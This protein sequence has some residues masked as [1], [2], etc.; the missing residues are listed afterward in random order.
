MKIT[1]KINYYLFNTIKSIIYNSAVC[2][3]KRYNEGVQSNKISNSNRLIYFNYNS[4]F[5]SFRFSF[6]SNTY[7]GNRRFSNNDV[8]YK[9]NINDNNINND[10]NI[11]ND[12]DIVNKNIEIQDNS[13]NIGNININSDYGFFIREGIFGNLDQKNKFIKANKDLFIKE[14]KII[15]FQKKS[16]GIGS[17]REAFSFIG[18]F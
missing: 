17:Y 2:C 8:L 14:S 4:P 18:S 7:L 9:S 16:K 11:I 1:Y 12:K 13:L 15:Q 5:N 3:S 6:L 10:S